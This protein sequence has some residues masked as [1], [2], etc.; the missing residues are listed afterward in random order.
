MG[1]ALAFRVASITMGT[2]CCLSKG[3]ESVGAMHYPKMSLWVPVC[4][5]VTVVSFS[6]HISSQSFSMWHS[7][8]GAMLPVS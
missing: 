5:R 7:H 2:A 3:V 1:T 8:R 4:I 6:S